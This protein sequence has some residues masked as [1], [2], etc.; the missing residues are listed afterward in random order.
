[1]ANNIHKFITDSNG[2]PT[3]C[4]WG[5]CLSAGSPL[6]YL[7]SVSCTEGFEFD[8]EECRCLTTGDINNKP[9]SGFGFQVPGEWQFAVSWEMKN[10]A[11]IPD[12]ELP[13]ASDLPALTAVAYENAPVDSYAA[14]AVARYDSRRKNYKVDI[15]PGSIVNAASATPWGS[16]K[17]LEGLRLSTDVFYNQ[18]YLEILHSSQTGGA[19]NTDIEYIKFWFDGEVPEQIV[20]V[21]FAD[22]NIHLC[23]PF[24]DDARSAPQSDRVTCQSEKNAWINYKAKVYDFVVGQRIASSFGGVIESPSTKYNGISSIIDYIDESLALHGWNSVSRNESVNAILN[25]AKL[26]TVDAAKDVKLYRNLPM[27]NG[28]VNFEDGVIRRD[29]FGKY[30]T[31]IARDSLRNNYPFEAGK[32]EFIINGDDYLSS[33]L[34]DEIKELLEPGGSLSGYGP[35]GP[36]DV[37]KTWNDTVRIPKSVWTEVDTLFTPVYTVLSAISSSYWSTSPFPG[38]VTEAYDDH[39]NLLYP[40]EIPVGEVIEPAYMHLILSSYPVLSSY[41]RINTLSAAAANP[42]WNPSLLTHVSFVSGGKVGSRN[43]IS[44]AYNKID[45]NEGADIGNTTLLT[46]GDTLIEVNNAY[47]GTVMGLVTDDY[48]VEPFIVDIFNPVITLEAGYVSG[49]TDEVRRLRQLGYI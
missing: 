6:S 23:A 38:S 32:T 43:V 34:D 49:V 4:F 45:L 13:S 15:V 1:M 31:S 25:S 39:L 44:L 14:L 36:I 33:D 11:F 29:Q 2:D 19:V 17:V 40:D 26:F 42:W 46:Y 35:G 5:N 10:K 37:D 16:E 47:N 27:D 41:A 20:D 21:Q 9:L 3:Y 8:C 22:N 18:D 28:V 7:A 30:I 48:E 12:I 24:A